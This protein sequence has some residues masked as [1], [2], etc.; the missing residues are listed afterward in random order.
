MKTVATGIAFAGLMSVGQLAAAPDAERDRIR[1]E[2]AA[3]RSKF[4]M[5]ERACQ[6]KFVVT[7]CVDAARKEQRETLARLRREEAVLDDATRR[8][9]A[10]ARSLA[11][12]DRAQ[13][14]DSRASE[15]AQ[16]GS[17]VD[18]RQPASRAAPS[19]NRARN[20]A[21]KP[22]SRSASEV[23]SQ[24]LIEQQNEAKFD[25]KARAAQARRAEVERRN[26]QRAAQGKAAAP[27]PLPAGASA[28]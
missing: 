24:R 12:R 5:Q 25:E 17:A 21:S 3:A 10:E 14:P 18:S 1:V 6:T 20:G 27:L 13:S 2:R 28:P 7:S 8:E 16:P 22:A 9:A 11:N 4:E 15:A 23:E 26:A 19:P